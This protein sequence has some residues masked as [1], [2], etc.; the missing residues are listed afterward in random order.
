MRGHKIRT[1]ASILILAIWFSG[2]RSE[3]SDE[4]TTTEPP[5]QEPVVPVGY[6]KIAPASV[7]SSKQM[8]KQT[9]SI[10]TGA[11]KDVQFTYDDL[12]RSADQLCVL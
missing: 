1:G 11:L 4:V 9:A 2:C 6:R 7:D 10:F 8:L 5:Q 3:Q 12:L